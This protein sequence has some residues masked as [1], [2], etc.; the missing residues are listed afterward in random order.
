[1]VVHKTV[2]YGQWQVWSKVGWEFVGFVYPWRASYGVPSGVKIKKLV[3]PQ[4]VPVRG[5]LE[6]VSTEVGNV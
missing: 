3:Y 6:G 5:L 2:P 4:G 1:M